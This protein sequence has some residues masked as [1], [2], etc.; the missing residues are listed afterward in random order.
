MHVARWEHPTC[1]PCLAALTCQAAYCHDPVTN[2]ALQHSNRS[3]GCASLAVSCHAPDT[4][5]EA[6][7]HS[8]RSAGCAARA[9]QRCHHGRFES[10]CRCFPSSVLASPELE[11][12]GHCCFLSSVLAS[13]EHESR[14]HCC[15][16]FEAKS[17]LRESP[18][19]PSLPGQLATRP[20][21]EST[22]PTGNH[23]ES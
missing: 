8:N 6:L 2:E 3:A 21:R 7:Q 10:S 18:I 5:N 20:T 22:R 12:R 11:S 23:S 17:R 15:R 14:G 4:N 1:K 19:T 16:H 13:P 9:G